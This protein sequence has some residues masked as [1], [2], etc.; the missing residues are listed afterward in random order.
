[1]ERDAANPEANQPWGWIAATLAACGA[2]LIG[3]TCGLEPQV[4][5]QRAISVAVAAGLTAVLISYFAS[6]PSN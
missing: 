2:T 3:V 5:L 1:M 6:L 4:I